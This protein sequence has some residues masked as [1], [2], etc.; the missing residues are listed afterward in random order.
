MMLK[1]LEQSGSW[2][3]AVIT[4]ETV[5]RHSVNENLCFLGIVLGGG[6]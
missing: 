3:G 5:K 6:L 4:E 2:V 1:K